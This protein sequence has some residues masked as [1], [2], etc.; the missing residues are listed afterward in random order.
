MFRKV[1]FGIDFES[2]I[3]ILGPNGIGKSTMVKVETGK[4]LNVVTTGRVDSLGRPG[5]SQSQ[6]ALWSFYA[7]PC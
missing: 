6:I 7:A 4:L 2:R 1:N 3:G 5:D